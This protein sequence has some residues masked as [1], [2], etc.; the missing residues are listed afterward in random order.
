M[1]D[2]MP[3]EDTDLPLRTPRQQTDE[4]LRVEREKSDRASEEKELQLEKQADI[5]VRV[6]RARADEIL[7]TSRDDSDRELLS[8]AAADVKRE[9]DLADVALT[10]ERAKA[11]AMLDRERVQRRRYIEIFLANER[12]ATDANLM[13]ERADA[14]TIV[15]MRDDFLAIVSH[16][17]RSLLNGLSLSA[18][19]LL[20]DAPADAA[21]DLA[22][23]C[24]K[25]SQRLVSRMSRLVNDLLDMAS[26]EA[27]KVALLIEANDVAD[28]V[29]DTLEA[30][31]PLA[32]A[33]GVAL[34]AEAKLIPCVYRFDAG[35]VLQVLANLVSNAIKFTPSGGRI[36]LSIE[37]ESNDLHFAL[38]DTGI[39]IPEDAL[40]GV[41]EKFKQVAKDRRGLGLGLYISKG[42]VQSHGGRMWA[43]SQLGAGSTFHFTIPTYGRRSL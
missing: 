14:D 41:F 29:R 27:G 19:V 12:E 15:D 3:K 11:D 6:A 7:K 28:V 38:S 24:A 34:S 26:I 32:A 10:H 9:R 1:E 31:E 16:D 2:Q 36:S 43:E 35:R 18:Q 30:F 21:G 37:R 13:D 42:I 25:T 8:S 39:G 20:E 5:V 4:S 40:P 33:K 17:L 22:R 23:K